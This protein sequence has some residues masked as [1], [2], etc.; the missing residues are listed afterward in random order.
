MTTTAKALDLATDLSGP[1]EPDCQRRIRA[2]LADPCD[3]TWDDAHLIILNGNTWRTL[4][5]AVLLI[6]PAFPTSSPVTD[7]AGRPLE[8]WTAIPSTFTIRR[9]IQLAV[10]GC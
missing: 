6:D 2:L 5:Q 4:W 3:E 10:E 1:L 8:P 7:A 9:A